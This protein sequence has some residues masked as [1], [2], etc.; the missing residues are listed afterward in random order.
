[1]KKRHI[2]KKIFQQLNNFQ[3]VRYGSDRFYFQTYF[4]DRFSRIKFVFHTIL[5]IVRVDPTTFY[6]RK[7]ALPLSQTF[8]LYGVKNSFHFL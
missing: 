5:N 3:R 1:M 7:E 8:T 4:L 2:R 6:T